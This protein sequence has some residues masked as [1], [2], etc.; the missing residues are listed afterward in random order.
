MII[1]VLIAGVLAAAGF[2]WVATSIN[3]ATRTNQ[4]QPYPEPTLSGP[5]TPA[6][7]NL[8]VNGWTVTSDAAAATLVDL[9]AKEYAVIHDGTAHPLRTG[10]DLGLRPY[11]QMVLD[12]LAAVQQPAAGSAPL[13]ALRFRGSDDSAAWWKRFRDEITFEAR[14]AGLSQP[15]YGKRERRLMR[16]S[17][18]IAALLFA[19]TLL[20]YSLGAAAGGFVLAFGFALVVGERREGERDTP[21][22][23]AA[24][25]RWLSVTDPSPAY[26]TA[27]GK[28]PELSAAL[29]FSQADRRT[30]W[31]SYGGY[32]HRIHVSYP[33]DKFPYGISGVRLLWMAALMIGLGGGAGVFLT[34]VFDLA[35]DA[36]AFSI[37]VT[38]FFD[39]LC[40]AGFVVA[41]F[42]L[43][44]AVRALLDI[45]APETVSGQVQWVEAWR[46]NTHPDDTEPGP[47]WLY[48]VAIDDG[49]TDRTTAWGLPDKLLAGVTEGVTITIRARTWSRRII[50]V[51]HEQ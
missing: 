50:E 7:V 25:S 40:L 21:A 30:L 12:R 32:W 9:T 10:V 24:A 46:R 39:A 38:Y 20:G 26:A 41:L 22:G 51:T 36:D 2:A 3:R 4:P 27:L 5:E 49:R 47:P 19:V 35:P 13:E 45:S 34:R 42:G 11:E 33:P 28:T 8:L 1:I 14:A 48:Y 23:L 29:P 43:R 17:A 31:S 15:R 16:G 37:G 6:V 44:I 18:A